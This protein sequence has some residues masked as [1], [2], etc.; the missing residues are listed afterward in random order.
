[1]DCNAWRI[2]PVGPCVR[3]WGY[4]QKTHNPVPT[5]CRHR[6]RCT[7]ISGAWSSKVLTRHKK[8]IFPWGYEPDIAVNSLIGT[9]EI[10]VQESVFCVSCFMFRDNPEAHT[11]VILHILTV[12]KSKAM[13]RFLIPRLCSGF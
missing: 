10:L 11:Y 9:R 2:A 12:A 7:R 3:G 5:F 13:T 4:T 8:V 6:S 1:M